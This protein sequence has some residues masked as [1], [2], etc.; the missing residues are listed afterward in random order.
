MRCPTTPADKKVIS[1][2]E[3]QTTN[4]A[5]ALKVWEKN[6][7]RSLEFASNGK[8]SLLMKSIAVVNPELTLADQY[9]LKTYVYTDEF[10]QKNGN[11]FL[12]Q[13]FSKLELDENGEP[14]MSINELSG[15]I[16]FRNP[17]KTKQEIIDYL[18]TAIELAQ[19]T[20]SKEQIPEIIP[21]T[22]RPPTELALLRQL[23]F[24]DLAITNT[25]HDY[26]GDTYLTRYRSKKDPYYKKDDNLMTEETIL[27]RFQN[28]QNEMK[29]EYGIDFNLF[30]YEKVQV[31]GK[32]MYE[33]SLI[34][35]AQQKLEQHFNK[36]VANQSKPQTDVTELINRIAKIRLDKLTELRDNLLD[37]N[38]DEI[39]ASIITVDKDNT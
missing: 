12:G 3:S 19:T 4:K 23:K 38:S 7:G 20:I 14:I 35:S 31:D 16:Y 5:L 18:N 30:T 39:Y 2:L 28:K 29:K 13:K 36:I 8:D 17:S 33:V 21:I 1:K 26:K 22:F 24:T 10:I 32:L 27:A 11:W 9:L 15:L 6:K 25:A 34:H 37:N